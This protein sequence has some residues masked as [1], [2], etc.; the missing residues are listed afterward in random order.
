MQSIESCRY[1]NFPYAIVN[2]VDNKCSC[3]V[4]TALSIPGPLPHLCTEDLKH[5]VM[6][7]NQKSTCNVVPYRS[8]K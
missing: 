4:E 3:S 7:E 6:S 2:N 1:E 8:T 5:K